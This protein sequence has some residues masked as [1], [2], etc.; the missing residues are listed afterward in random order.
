MGW[1]W[2]FQ[3]LEILFIFDISSI[4]GYEMSV[5]SGIFCRGISH[6]G[7]WRWG[8]HYVTELMRY[9]QLMGLP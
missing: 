6:L 1:L 8:V 5:F 9:I 7:H 2:F 3:I 4:V